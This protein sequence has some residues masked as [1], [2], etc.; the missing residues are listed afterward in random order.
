MWGLSIRIPLKQPGFHGKYASCCFC[1]WLRSVQ[2]TI[3]EAS[4]PPWE[5]P[6][7]CGKLRQFLSQSIRQRIWVKPPEVIS[8]L[9]TIAFP[10]ELRPAIKKPVFPVVEW[11]SMARGRL[12]WRGTLELVERIRSALKSRGPDAVKLLTFRLGGR[13]LA[14]EAVGFR[15][16][17]FRYPAAN[18]LM[19]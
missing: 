3:R 17:W 11:R 14:V 19:W 1:S 4:L 12:G 2:C 8:A 16:G 5:K 15:V 6:A 10:S 9:L 7:S 13:P 18:Q